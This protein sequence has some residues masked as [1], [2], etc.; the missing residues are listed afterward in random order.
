MENCLAARPGGEATRHQAYQVNDI[1][2]QTASNCHPAPIRTT[3]PDLYALKAFELAGYGPEVVERSF[4][5]MLN[6]SRY[7][8]RRRM[9]GLHRASTGS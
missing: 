9:A 8:A 2:L 3:G 5:R 4:W 7:G 1:V 6:A